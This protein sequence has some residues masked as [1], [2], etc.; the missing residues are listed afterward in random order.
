M[1]TTHLWYWID[2]QKKE[3][4]CVGWVEACFLSHHVKFIIIQINAPMDETKKA[5]KDD[6]YDQHQET[7][8]PIMTSNWLS[9]TWMPRLMDNIKQCSPTLPA[10]QPGRKGSRREMCVHAYANGCAHDGCASLCALV[11]AGCALPQHVI[12]CPHAC[13]NGLLMPVWCC[14]WC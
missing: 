12:W 13:A 1:K 2:S 5:D 6:F 14:Q 4:N 7:I 9:E 11:Q 8:L 3:G 10:W